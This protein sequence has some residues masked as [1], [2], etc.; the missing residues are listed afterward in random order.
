MSE[1]PCDGCPGEETL[2]KLKVYVETSVI[3]GLID[4]EPPGRQALARALLEALVLGDKFD[5]CIS[6]LVID[7]IMR[8]PEK[9]VQAFASFLSAGRFKRKAWIVFSNLTTV[10]YV[11]HG[12]LLCVYFVLW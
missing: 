2:K 5:A 7:E 12:L 8:A 3:G 1:Q 6:V 4:T 10:L 9:L 11:G